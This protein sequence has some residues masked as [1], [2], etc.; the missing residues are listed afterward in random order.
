MMPTAARLIA[1]LVLAATAWFTSQL[2]KP[3]LP[4]GTNFGWFDYLNVALGVVIGWIVIG[5]RAGRGRSAAIG[6]GI[7]ASAVLAFWAVFLQASNEMLRQSL[8]R[9]YKGPTEA[10]LDVF[11]MCLEFGAYVIKPDVLI[12]LVVGGLL[13]G[14]LS[15]LA[16]RVWR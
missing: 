7:T 11:D 6:N 2:V 4:E 10:I 12:A 16:G 5:R 3:Y 13:A 1:A 14:L 9:R 15:E 8:N